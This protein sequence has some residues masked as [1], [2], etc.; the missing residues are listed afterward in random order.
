[1]AMVTGQPLGAG[2]AVS[3]EEAL[4]FHGSLSHTTS[5]LTQIGLHPSVLYIAPINMC[6]LS[7]IFLWALLGVI[8]QSRAT[9]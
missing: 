7:S 9:K 8:S 6:L 2:M 4:S 5:C 1:M 3:G